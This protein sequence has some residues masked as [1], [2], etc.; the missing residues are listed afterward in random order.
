[1]IIQFTNE[2]LFNQA[3]GEDLFG[4]S[5]VITDVFFQ[6][7]FMAELRA[8]N[9]YEPEYFTDKEIIED[10]K[11]SFRSTDR[12]LNNMLYNNPLPEF[13][14]SSDI[15]ENLSTLVVD[16]TMIEGFRTMG[17][18]ISYIPAEF[19][20]P[21]Y[22]N[23]ALELREDIVTAATEKG[24]STLDILNRDRNSILIKYPSDTFII[25]FLVQVKDIEGIPLPVYKFFVDTDNYCI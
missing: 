3:E 4:F 8:Y 16:K 23:K 11:E 22:L 17:R 20:P 7:P 24:I 18:L 21:D 19:F 15:N 9:L 1:M 6:D 13:R 12:K 14:I 10:I 5:E 2:I 25:K